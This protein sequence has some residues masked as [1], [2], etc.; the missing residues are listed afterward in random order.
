MDILEKYVSAKQDRLQASD[1]PGTAKWIVSEVISSEKVTYN[2]RGEE[3][4]HYR[5]R[6]VMVRRPSRQN[7][8]ELVKRKIKK[9][10][11]TDDEMAI[12]RQRDTKPD[13]FNAYNAYVEQCKVQAKQE[14]GITGEAVT[15]VAPEEVT[16]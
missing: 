10:Y 6:V 9:K 11:S 3:K 8:V 4:S 14:L 12:L 5:Y 7:Y 15:Y 2:Y 13:E 1:F 16:E